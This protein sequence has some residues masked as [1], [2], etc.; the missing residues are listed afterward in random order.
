MRSSN[1]CVTIILLRRFILKNDWYSNHHRSVQ[2]NISF[3]CQRRMHINR[4]R[5]MGTLY[6]CQCYLALLFNRKLNRMVIRSL[7]NQ[8][9]Y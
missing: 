8:N 6:I 4:E 9:S 3:L 7:G 1:G 5:R 2:Y